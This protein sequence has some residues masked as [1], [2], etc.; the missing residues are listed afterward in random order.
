MAR[1]AQSLQRR[2]QIYFVEAQRSTNGIGT[3][4]RTKNQSRKNEKSDMVME[5]LGVD[6]TGVGNQKQSVNNIPAAISFKAALTNDQAHLY[7]GS[8][9]EEELED[10]IP[11]PVVVKPWPSLD[12]SKDELQKLRR[13]WRKALIVKLLGRTVGY[14]VLRQRVE[15]AWKLR[16]NFQMVDLEE[17][18]YLVRFATK[19]DYHHVLF[20]GPWTI[21]GHYLTAQKWKPD[22]VPSREGISSTMVWVRFPQLPIEYFDKDF[23]LRLGNCIGKAVKVD[24]PSSKSERGKFAR[25]CVQLDLTQSLISKVTVRSLDYCVEYEGL[26]SICF[27]CGK[28]GHQK[29]TCPNL[30]VSKPQNTDMGGTSGGTSEPA[31]G[32]KR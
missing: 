6:L 25:V 22:F 10:E 11:E 5:D 3:R 18:Y 31:A 9:D 12:V 14:R 20:Y 26:H 8:D 13:P 27:E 4:R 32:S 19:E 28:Y 21:L 24:V 17:G 30:V 15:Q 23:L 29:D 16:G 2:K 7:E 1:M